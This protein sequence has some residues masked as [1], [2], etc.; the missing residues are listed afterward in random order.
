MA[1]IA[2]L[3]LGYTS[4]HTLSSQITPYLPGEPEVQRMLAMAVVYIAVSGGVFGLAWMIRGTLRKLKFEA[5]DRHLGMLLGGLEGVGVGLLVTMFVVSLAPATREPIF[6]SPTGRVVGTVMNNVGPVLPQEIRNVLAPH[7]E[8]RSLVNQRGGRSG[9]RPEARTRPPHCMTPKRQ[10]RSARC[11]PPFTR[12][13]VRGIRPSSPPALDLPPL[14]EVPAADSVATQRGIPDPAGP[15]R[16]SGVTASMLKGIVKDGRKQVE[17]ALVE[18]L[19][20]TEGDQKPASL[21]ELVNRDKQRVKAAVQ[22]VGKS[23]QKLGSQ[24]KDRLA[25]GQ[26]DLE[27][28][29]SESVIKGHQQV[30]QAVSDAIDQQL[31]K[32]GGLESAPQKA[33][34]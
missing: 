18:T 23:K 26:Q 30:D 12:R 32:L 4:A 34:R 16:D 11:F 17:Q 7:W 29:V 10:A 8:R 27:Q 20:T 33:P 25:K 5:F 15:R 3:I 1:S 24:V 13:R 28:A 31:R 21:R 19:D 6:T 2:S 22:N 14:E 9:C